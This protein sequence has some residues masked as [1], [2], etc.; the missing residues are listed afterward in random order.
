MAC[1]IRVGPALARA[2]RIKLQRRRMSRAAPV[3]KHA[4][5]ASLSYCFNIFIAN[6]RVV[7]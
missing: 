1:T 5:N 7:R 6:L 4:Q 3:G 2:V